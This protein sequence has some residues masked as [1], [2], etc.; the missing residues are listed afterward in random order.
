M[1]I[2]S[3][4]TPT[5]VTIFQFIFTTNSN[6]QYGIFS[7]LSNQHINTKNKNNRLL[8]TFTIKSILFLSHTKIPLNIKTKFHTA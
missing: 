4:A 3:I 2:Q 6:Q 8:Q 7:L 5:E 1:K